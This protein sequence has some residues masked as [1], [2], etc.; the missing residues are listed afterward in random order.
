MMGNQNIN[1]KNPTSSG[2]GVCQSY[3]LML[4]VIMRREKVVKIKRKNSKK[5]RGL[6]GSI[7]LSFLFQCHR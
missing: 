1:F 2:V 6:R 3:K 7:A 5:L 4:E